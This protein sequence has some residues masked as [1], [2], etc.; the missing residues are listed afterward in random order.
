MEEGKRWLLAA[1]VA[2]MF[3]VDRRTVTRWA[4]AGQLPSVQTPGGQYR[5]ERAEIERI[6]AEGFEPSQTVEEA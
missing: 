2:G 6:L 3:R 1:E 5:Y 4:Q